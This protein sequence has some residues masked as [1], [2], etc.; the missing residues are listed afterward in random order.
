MY[1]RPLQIDSRGLLSTMD[2]IFVLKKESHFM[3][4]L[5]PFHLPIYRQAPILKPSHTCTSVLLTQ[6]KRHQIK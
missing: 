5:I 4:I 1:V 6:L 3:I 2:P